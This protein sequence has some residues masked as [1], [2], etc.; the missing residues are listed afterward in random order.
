MFSG[1][2]V[3]V[4]GGGNAGFESAA[5][6][7]AY[8]KSVTLINRTETFKADE[9]TVEVFQNAICLHFFL[10]NTSN[11]L[12]EIFCFFRHNLKKCVLDCF[13]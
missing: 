9:I 1:M 4:V 3:V 7:L 6:L 12:C 11:I 13:L 2:D 8:C 10:Q 5:Q